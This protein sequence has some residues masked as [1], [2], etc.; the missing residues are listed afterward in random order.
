MK[1]NNIQGSPQGLELIAAARA[2]AVAVD[3]LLPLEEDQTELYLLDADATVLRPLYERIMA[4]TQ[5]AEVGSRL[6]DI[7]GAAQALAPYLRELLPPGANQWEYGVVDEAEARPY[8]DRLLA[9][10]DA[11]ASPEQIAQGRN[12]EAIR[13]LARYMDG[14][15]LTDTELKILNEISRALIR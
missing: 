7:V 4:A 10:L 5:A 14:P 1:L 6:D 15:E 9:A 3:D 12:D 13:V 8:I 2:L 11:I